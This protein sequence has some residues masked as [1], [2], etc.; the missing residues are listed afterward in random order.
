MGIERFEH[1]RK[2]IPAQNIIVGLDEHSGI[3]MDCEQGTCH[4]QGLGSVSVLKP[5]SMEIH[6]TG[7]SF[8][9]SELGNYIPPEP[10]EKGID[11]KVWNMALNS[12]NNEP[13][14]ETP[15]DE[16]LSLLEQRRQAR[17]NKNF[18]ESDRLRGMITALG[19]AVQ[20]GR[21]GQKLL[22]L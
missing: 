19:W 9:L 11:P 13:E 10:I 12:I 3:I 6:P 7:A 5:D 17:V 4:V 20:D 2:L 18:P 14:A 1:W 21:E 16:V 8:S 22:K 15:S